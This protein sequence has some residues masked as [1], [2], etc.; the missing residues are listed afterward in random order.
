VV[1]V[2]DKVFLADPPEQPLVMVEIRE[3]LGL[4]R[5]QEIQP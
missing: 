3:M 4:L 2:V 5:E 1:V